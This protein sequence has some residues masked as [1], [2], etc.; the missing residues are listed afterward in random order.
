MAAF[1]GPKARGLCLLD[2]GEEAHVRLER[3]AALTTRPAKDARCRDGVEEAGSAIAREDLLPCGFRIEGTG[4]RGGECDLWI[5][6]H[7]AM[8]HDVQFNRTPILARNSDS[9]PATSPSKRTCRKPL[10]QHGLRSHQI[11]FRIHTNR[12]AR[13]RRYIDVDTVFEQP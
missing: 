1:A 11:L 3:A 9:F 7:V 2:C 12:V 5:G 8:V 4:R 10:L 13:C 6:T